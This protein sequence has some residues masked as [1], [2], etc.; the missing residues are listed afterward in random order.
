[1]YLETIV[2]RHESELR[3]GWH[4]LAREASSL[5]IYIY[6]TNTMKYE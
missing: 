1:M 3:L 4:S 2:M 5:C 6:T